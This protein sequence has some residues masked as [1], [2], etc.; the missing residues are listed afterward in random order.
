MNQ[1]S[2][3]GDRAPKACA[4]RFITELSE[5]ISAL[6]RG[7]QIV[8]ALRIKIVSTTSEQALLGVQFHRFRSQRRNS[9][10]NVFCVTER[11]DG[12]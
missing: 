4:T 7:S 3:I 5:A 11:G 9:G 10:I 2:D 1:G 8:G 12:C 6:R